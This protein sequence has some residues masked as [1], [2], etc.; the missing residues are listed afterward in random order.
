MLDSRKTLCALAVA[1]AGCGASTPTFVP[2]P[3]PQDQA[4]VYVY[5]PSRMT[6]GLVPFA[7]TLDEQGFSIWSGDYQAFTVPPGPHSVRI[8]TNEKTRRE[9]TAEAHQAYYAR[10]LPGFTAK[11]EVVD[12]AVGAQEI[13]RCKPP[14]K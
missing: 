11:I 13:T 7:V 2:T 8:A 14:G 9:F 5:R 6:G 3:L 4:V 1:V 10:V 12:P